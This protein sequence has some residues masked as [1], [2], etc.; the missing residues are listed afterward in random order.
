M[1]I[2]YPEKYLKVRNRE[3]KWNKT[4]LGRVMAYN[5]VGW[6][7]LVIWANETKNINALVGKIARF[8][9]SQRKVR[10]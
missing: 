6:D 2:R 9:E 3:I 7:C 5:S 1:K 4:E 10:V 8:V